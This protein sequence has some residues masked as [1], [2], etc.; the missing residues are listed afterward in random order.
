MVNSLWNDEQFTKKPILF[1][2][3]H[4][5]TKLYQSIES[6]KRILLKMKK[7]EN[8]QEHNTRSFESL[9]CLRVF[10][11]KSKKITI[12]LC[13]CFICYYR[14]IIFRSFHWVNILECQNEVDKWIHF[15]CPKWMQISTQM[16]KIRFGNECFL[17]HINI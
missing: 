17:N 10:C 12:T 6:Y 13:I 7:I 2:S 4:F 8:N 14:L 3:I 5:A 16:N 1:S 9:N 15:I 11:I